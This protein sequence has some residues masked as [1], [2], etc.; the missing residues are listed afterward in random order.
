MFNV[1]FL[2]SKEVFIPALNFQ[3]GMERWHIDTALCQWNI[4]VEQWEA[5]FII[6]HGLQNKREGNK[7]VLKKIP[8]Q[9]IIKFI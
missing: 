1:R 7:I 3:E 6:F 2:I 4:E 9:L 5:Q 8:T